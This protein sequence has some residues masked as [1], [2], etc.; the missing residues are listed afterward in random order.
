MEMSTG[1][2]IKRDIDT[3]HGDAMI[4]VENTGKKMRVN[5]RGV[6]SS[7][8]SRERNGRGVDG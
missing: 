7:E 6:G 2:G 8:G 5:S 4:D 3:D 1:S